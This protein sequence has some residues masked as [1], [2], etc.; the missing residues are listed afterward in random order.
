MIGTLYIVATPIG[1]LRDISI[2]AVETLEKVAFIVCEDTRMATILLNFI[3]KGLQRPFVA[4]PRP[5]LLKYHEEKEWKIIPK[6]TTILKNG[7]DVALISDAGTPTI[8]DPGFKLVREC[9]AG[10]IKVESI[11]GASAS[12]VALTVSGLPTDK[13][14][15]L[16]FLP[17]KPGNRTKLLE[18]AKISLNAV[19]STTIIYEAPHRIIKTLK[20]LEKIFGNIQIVICR[21]LTKIHEEVRREKLS[22]SIAYF[23]QSRPRGEFVILFNLGEQ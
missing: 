22:E 9:I 21:E 1:N 20:E 5:H 6:I 19:K 3:E 16:G 15:F 7:E 17:H 4:H 23:E 14:L 11:P 2:R 8:S 10:E 13:F 18:N 12:I